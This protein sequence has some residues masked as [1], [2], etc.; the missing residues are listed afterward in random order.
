M[1]VRGAFLA[2]TVSL[3]VLSAC[4]TEVDRTIAPTPLPTQIP[5]ATPQPTATPTPTPTPQPTA[6]PTAVPTPL[7]TP[8]PVPGPLPD[9]NID[10]LP[11]VFVGGVTINSLAAPDGTQVTVWVS[12]YS[13][14][15][16]TGFTTGGNYSVLVHQHGTESFRGRSLIFKVNGQDTGETG[17]WETGGATILAI[18]LDQR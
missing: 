11:N 12:E 14:P 7:P 15:V 2:L 16:G 4:F 10:V 17:I 6:T 3:L 5:T 8:T 18:S 1:R 13:G 9:R